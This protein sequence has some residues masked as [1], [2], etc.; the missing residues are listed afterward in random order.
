MLGYGRVTVVPT[1]GTNLGKEDPVLG[2]IALDSRDEPGKGIKQTV[3]SL[4][5]A[6]LRQGQGLEL[7]PVLASS[8]SESVGRVC[9]GGCKGVEE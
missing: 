1:G 8:S 6:R 4:T 2:L 9:L 3:P 7:E 5:R